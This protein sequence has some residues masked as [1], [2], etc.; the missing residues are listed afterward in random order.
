[1][2][3]AYI[4]IFDS[5]PD[6]SRFNKACIGVR[7]MF[8]VESKRRGLQWLNNSHSVRVGVRTS[9]FIQKG[10]KKTNYSQGP[11]AKEWIR[12]WII[13]APFCV[14]VYG[15]TTSKSTIYI[16]ELSLGIAMC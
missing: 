16:G 9:I 7:N 4:L 3:R 6:E 13:S 14:K 10:S 2:Y 5:M 11:Q 8:I 1:M 12:L 15:G